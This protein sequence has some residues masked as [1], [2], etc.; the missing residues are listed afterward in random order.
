MIEIKGKKVTIIGFSRTG[1]AAARMLDNRGAEVTVSDIK[2]REQLQEQIEKLSNN[3]INYD[4]D[5]H[6]ESSLDCD[7]IVVSPG[8]PLTTPFF[9][10]AR[11]RKIPIISEV[12][13]AYHFTEANLIAITGTN[14]KTTTT[15]LI[16]EILKKAEIGKVKVAGNIGI[17]LVQEAVG[18]TS[19]D[20]VVVEVS[21]FQLETIRDFRPDISLFLNFTP[22]HLDRH[23]TIE[24]YWKAKKRIFE[25][26]TETD[27]A[28]IN[29]DDNEVVRAS[30]NIKSEK[31]QISLSE[32]VDKG[33]YL[34]DNNLMLKDSSGIINKAKIT[35]SIAKEANKNKETTNYEEIKIIS[36]AEIPL[37]GDHNIQNTAF[38]A[39]AAY[40]AGVDLESIR[41]GI[42]NFEAAEHRLEVVLKKDNRVVIDD[43]KAT[44]PDAAVKALEAVDTPVVLIAG[45]QDRDADFKKF[46]KKIKDRVKALILLGETK[47]K[48]KAEVLN[49][50]INNIDI[51]IVDN[52]E[53]AVAKSITYFKKGDCLLLAPGCP[54]WDM[55]SSYKVRGNKFQ[56]EV[57]KHLRGN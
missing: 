21:S 43:S 19:E 14:G 5:G 20:W 55:Y 40:L 53:E 36:T 23:K 52:M 28:V 50:G 30:D 9:K 12:E 31:Y 34:K 47:N 37:L 29:L 2:S 8:V 18:L 4:L 24:N 22:D 32:E 6:S 26:Q 41:K 57:M 49:T 16:G 54:S 56:Q 13:L 42:K 3:S 1:V 39:T 38:A 44:N 46:A 48:I 35:S 33:I 11:V 10:K 15:S 27:Y 45:G 25:N 17:P 7:Y 51:E